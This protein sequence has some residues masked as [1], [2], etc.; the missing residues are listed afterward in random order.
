MKVYPLVFLALTMAT[1]ASASRLAQDDGDYG[2]TPIF[3]LPHPQCLDA[4]GS[5]A[6]ICAMTAE[7][8]KDSVFGVKHV[9]DFLIVGDRSNFTL[10]LT[11][12]EP[13]APEP[14]PD[15]SSRLSYGAF[16]CNQFSVIQCGPDPTSQMAAGSPTLSL[17]GMTA[18]FD[19]AGTND[20]NHPFVF[21]AVEGSVTATLTAN[22]SAVPEPGTFSLIF[23]AGLA[24]AALGRRRLAK[25]L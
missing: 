21:F 13:F 6:A 17:D 7:D 5:P 4:S 1:V 20:G 8:W 3:S 24:V 22:A 2:D 16:A 9:F 14:D 18:T 10:T 23:G 11:G 25:L 12:T 19:V 15:N